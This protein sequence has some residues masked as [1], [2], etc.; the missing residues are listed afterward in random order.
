MVRNRVLKWET[1]SK[2]A[3]GKGKTG[4]SVGGHSTTGREGGVARGGDNH[5]EEAENDNEE[6]RITH[7]VG[8]HV[9]SVFLGTAFYG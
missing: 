8:L 4:S 7:V 3:V 2:A 6:C 1:C 9:A 5:S